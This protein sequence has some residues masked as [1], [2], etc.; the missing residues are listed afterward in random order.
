MAPRELVD[1]RAAYDHAPQ[2]Q[3]PKF[4]PAELHVAKEALDDAEQ[5]FAD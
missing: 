1:A 2:S 3:A 5:K 4:V